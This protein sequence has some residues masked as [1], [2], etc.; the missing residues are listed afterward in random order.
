M[1]GSGGV[2][3]EPP[4]GAGDERLSLRRAAA[5]LPDA[6]G[7]LVA[8]TAALLN[9][10]RR[11]RFCSACGRPSDIVEGGLTRICPNC[12]AEHH[13]RTDP[14]VIMLVTDG[15]RLT[16]GRQASWPDGRYSAL[17]GFV[18]PGEALEEA[19]AREVWEESGVLVGRP[20][21]VDSQP[22]P[23]PA[24]LMLGFSAPYESGEREIRDDELQDVRWF[25]RA[26]IERR[27]SRAR[28]RRLGHA[29]RPRRPAAAPAAPG[30]RTAP[31]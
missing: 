6:E 29:R 2:R 10:H 18:E 17:A 8:Y 24:S 12:G 13:P 28:R 19:V 1:V 14:V 22:W 11:H 31:D 21:Y 26:E 4:A 23:F 30:H 15:D 9:W 7:G 16:L 5:I 27:R 25:A 20:R 3:G